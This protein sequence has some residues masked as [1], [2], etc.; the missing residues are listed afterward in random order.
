M[1]L[2]IYYII[3]LDIWIVKQIINNNSWLLR[4]NIHLKCFQKPLPHI[5]LWSSSSYCADCG[6]IGECGTWFLTVNPLYSIPLFC[7]PTPQL[8]LSNPNT[9]PSDRA[10]IPAP[11]SKRDC[12]HWAPQIHF[13][14]SVVLYKHSSRGQEHAWQSSPAGR[15]KGPAV[16]PLT[17]EVPLSAHLLSF[18][19]PQLQEPHQI[20]QPI[21]SNLLLIPVL[22]LILNKALWF[23]K[24]FLFS[25]VLLLSSSFSFFCLSS[26]KLFCLV[27]CMSAFM[28]DTVCF[29]RV[30][31][32]QDSTKKK[33]RSSI[34]SL[35]YEYSHNVHHILL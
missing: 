17:E 27:F 11:A 18:R 12:V 30:C 20:P 34:Y 21:F 28:Y 5:S 6:D 16:Y 15:H 23:S 14:R 32:K 1:W 29:S 9:S 33:K 13:S 10:D 25:F 8:A 19:H 35:K 22:T 2:N 4:V 3:T 26:T 31:L 24:T 7:P